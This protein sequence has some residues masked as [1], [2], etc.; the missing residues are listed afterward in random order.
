MLIPEPS[1]VFGSAPTLPRCSR[2]QTL[3]RPRSIMRRDFFPVISTTKPT[4]HESFSLIGL[5]KPFTSFTKP[6]EIS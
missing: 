2:L 3:S 6:F 4:P 5:Y 1:P